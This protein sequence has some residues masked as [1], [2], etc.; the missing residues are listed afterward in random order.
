MADGP[1]GSGRGEQGG[2]GGRGEGPG[3][4]E[5]RGL[6]ARPDTGRAR[7]RLEAE[8][9]ALLASLD[10]QRQEGR[11]VS[12]QL[13]AQELSGY[14]QHQAD[15]GS[16]VELR[17]KELGLRR[18]L[19]EELVE[20]EAALG[21]IDA[22]T[23]GFCPDCGRPIPPARLEAMPRAARCAE[24]QARQEERGGPS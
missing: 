18:R 14:D 21:R 7:A 10:R 23:Y 17:A 19:E 2:G 13:G 15:L 1:G 20:V 4:R 24:C 16:Q 5:G 9:R 6:E 3:G 11:L 8:R 12:E 22:G